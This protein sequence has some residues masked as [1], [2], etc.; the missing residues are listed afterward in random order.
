MKSLRRSELI[1]I[2]FEP[3]IQ[4]QDGA[5]FDPAKIG[6]A[7]VSVGAVQLE[8]GAIAGSMCLAAYDLILGATGLTF[9]DDDAINFFSPRASPPGKPTEAHRPSHSSR[10]LRQEDRARRFRLH[11]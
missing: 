1:E 8:P 2:E 5:N 9:F 3:G 7:A 4:I 6:M 10:V 11:P